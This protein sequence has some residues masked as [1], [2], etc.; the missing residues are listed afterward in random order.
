MVSALVSYCVA[1]PYINYLTERS[2]LVA[3]TIIIYRGD[4][5]SSV[6]L[7]KIIHLLFFS[8]IVEVLM[9]YGTC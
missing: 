6:N 9:F 4:L 3:N 7:S 5:N 1:E 2:D 8:E